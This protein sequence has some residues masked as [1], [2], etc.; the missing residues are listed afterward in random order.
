MHFFT[1]FAFDKYIFPE[2]MYFC[3]DRIVSVWWIYPMR[4]QIKVI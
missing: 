3:F 1:N 4:Y 2:K